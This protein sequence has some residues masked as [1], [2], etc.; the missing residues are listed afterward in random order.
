MRPKVGGVEK[1]F[2]NMAVRLKNMVSFVSRSES[3]K[4]AKTGPKEQQGRRN[5]NLVV[6]MD[7][8]RDGAAVVT[9]VGIPIKKREFAREFDFLIEVGTH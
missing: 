4:S 6:D 5:G 8:R 2:L 7:L 3:H 9:I 1:N